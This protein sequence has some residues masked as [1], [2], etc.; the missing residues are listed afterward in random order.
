MYVMLKMFF[1]RLKKRVKIRKTYRKLLQIVIPIKVVFD[2][3]LFRGNF[4]YIFNFL[5]FVNSNTVSQIHLLGICSC[6]KCGYEDP[7][8]EDIIKILCKEKGVRDVH[9]KTNKCS[10]CPGIRRL[11]GV[12]CDYCG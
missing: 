5:C 6:G 12:S 10:N 7:E 1:K 8:C 2:C 11:C 9:Y 4:V 3:I